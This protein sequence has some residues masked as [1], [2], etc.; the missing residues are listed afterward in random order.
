MTKLL[1]N[2]Y[3]RGFPYYIYRVYKAYRR[4]I[5]IPVPPRLKSNA[6]RAHA[7]RHGLTTLVETGTYYGDTINALL[8]DFEAIYSIEYDPFLWERARKRF[9]PHPHVHCLQGD[10]AVKLPELLQTLQGPCL[11]WLDAH[12]SG[13]ITGRAV[14]DTPIVQEL[15]TIF[16]H[17][18]PGHVILIDDARLFNGENDYPTLEE[19]EDHLHAAHPAW[20]CRTE[21]DI[22]RITLRPSTAR[23]ERHP[24]TS[25]GS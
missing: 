21:N 14:K 7:Q 17:G 20:K 19:L 2:A 1:R 3:R 13:G 23:S 4:G 6:I 9:A 11:F 10:S 12:Y 16:A 25:T 5:P 22:I 15:E 8:N 18:H 24:S